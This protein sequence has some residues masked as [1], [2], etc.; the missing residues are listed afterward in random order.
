MAVSIEDIKTQYPLPVYNYRVDIGSDAVAFSEVSG[1]SISY[2]T[3]TYKESPV[4]S[5]K[6]GPRVMIMP[7]QSQ[8]PTISLKKGLVPAVSVKVLYDWIKGIQTNQIEK[9]DISVSLCN[10]KGEPVVTWKVS[11]AFPTKLEAPTFDS[12][13]NDVAIE[14]MELMA[15]GISIAEA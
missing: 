14:S 4:E 13:S 1:L 11:N 12:N 6:P 7:S 15:D 2:E 5:G 9:K 8:P 10:E 3:S